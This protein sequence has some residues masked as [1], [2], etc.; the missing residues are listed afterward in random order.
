MENTN[1]KKK[2]KRI[3]FKERARIIKLEI[4]HLMLIQSTV[5]SQDIV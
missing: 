3:S 2:T 5:N 4:K 1:E